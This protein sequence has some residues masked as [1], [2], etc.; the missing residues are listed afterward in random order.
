MP[1]TAFVPCLLAWGLVT[2]SFAHAQE[3]APDAAAPAD[4]VAS[5]SADSSSVAS[6]GP[7]AAQTEPVAFDDRDEVERAADEF[8]ADRIVS[9]SKAWVDQ[10]R[11]GVYKGVC[12]SAR[13]IDGFFGDERID[14]EVDSTFGRVGL[15]VYW[16]EVDQLSVRGKLK[17]RIALPRLE[18]RWNAFIGRFDEE[19]F[20]SDREDP[21][22]GPP[23]AFRDSTD[24]E[25]LAGLGYSP[26]RNAK[27]RIDFDAGVKLDFPSDPFVRGRYRRYIFF[28]D[29]TLARLQ[30]TVFWRRENG[31]GTTSAA[32]LE[33]SLSPQFHLRWRGIG[34]WAEKVDGVDW[35]TSVTLY[36]DLEQRRALA[37]TIGWDGETDAPVTVEEYGLQVR[38]RQAVMREWFFLE[39]RSG[40]EWKRKAH[41]APRERA[42]GIGIG[43]EMYF[44]DWSERFRR[45]PDEDPDDRLEG[46]S[47]ESSSDVDAGSDDV[48]PRPQV[49]SG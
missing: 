9:G 43:F 32:E 13:W 3:S 47:G 6:P 25:W 18:N 27:R 26:V 31:Y 22:V 30:Q 2:A 33:R 11:G 4:S 35:Q 28:G 24:R 45:D 10:M 48:A 46:E 36:Q 5:S 39:L 38:Y 23:E 21:A 8:C 16:D 41:D 34:T 20:V 42:V 19:D 7:D 1:R 17:V 40:L 12:E 15:G 14:H 49:S 37:Y 44:G 29:L